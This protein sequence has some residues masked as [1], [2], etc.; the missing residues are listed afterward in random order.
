[1]L[2]SV[3]VGTSNH[4]SEVSLIRGRSLELLYQRRSG[5]QPDCW[6]ERCFQHRSGFLFTRFIVQPFNLLARGLRQDFLAVQFWHG[7]STWKATEGRR[8]TALSPVTSSGFARRAR[9]TGT[10]RRR[11][12]INLGEKDAPGGC[13]TAEQSLERREG[14]SNPAGESRFLKRFIKAAAP[15][16]RGPPSVNARCVCKGG[17]A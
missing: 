12:N 9:A 8:R 11:Q 3:S 14:E 1:V 2:L 13:Q 6:P 17:A 15:P 4:H 5:D 10:C 7:Y 16:R